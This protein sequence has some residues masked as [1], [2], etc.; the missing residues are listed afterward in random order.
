[1][2]ENRIGLYT[3]DG[4]EESW[5]ETYTGKYVNPLKMKPDDVD[6]KDI[7]HALS[8]ICRFNGHCNQF[9]SVAEHSIRVANLVYGKDDILTALLHDA[10]EAYMADI[11]RPV[12]W[13]LP[14]IRKVEGIIAIAINER[15]GLKGDW[16][17]VKQA[18]NILLATE[19]R[20]LMVSGGRGWYLPLKPI[21][22]PIIPMTSKIAEERFLNQY[23]IYG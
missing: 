19:A 6:I 1:M 17:K 21:E 10:T 5:I 2:N 7:A 20:D 12:K 13:A 8:L 23:W 14:D 3:V 15:F 4:I 9:Y 11:T 18:D 22:S 16:I